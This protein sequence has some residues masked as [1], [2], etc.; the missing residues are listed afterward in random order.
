MNRIKRVVMLGRKPFLPP[1]AT[2]WA[3]RVGTNQWYEIDG[4]GKRNKGDRNTINGGLTGK[5]FKAI[6]DI[7]GKKTSR[8]GAKATHLA[9]R[10]YKSDAEIKRWNK[11]F[12][13]KHPKYNLMV[14]NCQVYTQDFVQWLTDGVYLRWKQ[15]RFICDFYVSGM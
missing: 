13:S 5:A 3:V 8:A 11:K 4:A 9:G 2:H 12:L 1:L 10:T 7:K 14:V 15:V 6:I